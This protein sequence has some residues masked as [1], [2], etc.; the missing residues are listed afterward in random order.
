MDEMF[1]TVIQILIL[2]L[3]IGSK[4]FGSKNNTNTTSPQPVP[5]PR[6]VPRQSNNQAA[7]D[8]LN[9]LFAQQGLSNR[10][11]PQ[12]NLGEQ[13]KNGLEQLI[14]GEVRVRTIAR[15]A[16]R[17]GDT[18]RK[19][20]TEMIVPEIQK[21]E[22][23]LNRALSPSLPA[24]ERTRE[25][26]RLDLWGKKIH[27]Q[28]RILEGMV[29]RQIDKTLGDM[30][31]DA[32]AIAIAFLEPLQSFVKTHEV[33]M[34]YQTPLCIPAKKGEEA[35]F[36]GIFRDRPLIFVPQNF[37]SHLFRWISVPHEIGHV[38]WRS[39][40]GLSEEIHECCE[41]KSI[42]QLQN[43]DGRAVNAVESMYA[44]WLPEIFA[45]FITVMLAGPSALHG[46]LHLYDRYD[47]VDVC[48]MQ[49]N[50]YVD[51]HP[52]PVIRALLM[53]RL[54]ERIDY[55][56]EAIEF[57]R[58]WNTRHGDVREIVISSRQTAFK[59]P[60]APILARGTDIML[61]LY[62][63]Q[64]EALSGRTF[65]SIP[66]FEMTLGLWNR[67]RKI[68][69]KLVE[70]ETP[71]RN[72]R[73]VLVG[74]VEAAYYNPES[75]DDIV[76]GTRAAIIGKGTPVRKYN[77]NRVSRLSADGKVSRN[78]LRDAI[79]L[80]E[81]LRRPSVQKPAANKKATWPKMMTPPRRA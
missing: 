27:S 70:R 38:I 71:E 51:E 65:A 3:W 56:E 26:Q 77:A 24:R 60:I 9:R 10:Q 68:G 19:T 18:V 1:G 75:I 32:D 79:V 5:Q 40:D 43:F 61:R 7:N 35:T 57:Q 29:S 46:M 74:A 64:F 67:S 28:L 39:I 47:R 4:F 25:Q 54:L 53:I 58:R 31:A 69:K 20:L 33:Q 62:Q 17:Y 72:P 66:S 63:T 42:P 15:D 14:V 13:L 45:D 11:P 36:L 6:P 23:E 21:F 59:L 81:L 12:P 76:E 55:L 48:R 78:E 50:G 30:L 52:P 22:I 44:G 49:Q 34:S 8:F 41:I 16:D 37:H 80:S 73:L 2:A